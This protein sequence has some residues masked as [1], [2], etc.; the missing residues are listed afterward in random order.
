MTES[1]DNECGPI[2]ADLVASKR[3]LGDA[4]IRL[5]G[6]SKRRGPLDAHIIVRHIEL[7][8]AAV[9]GLQYLRQQRSPTEAE[10][11]Q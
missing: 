3:E 10:P 11:S 9:P 1:I 5:Q 6:V 2:G 7:S 4:D 8:Y